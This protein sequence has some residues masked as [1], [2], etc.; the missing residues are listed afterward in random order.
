MGHESAM[1]RYLIRLLTPIGLW[2]LVSCGGSTALVGPSLTL[3][4]LPVLP[5]ATHLGANLQMIQDWSFTPVY[6]DLMHQARKFGSPQTPWDEAAKLGSDGWPSGDF[7]ALLLIGATKYAGNAGTYKLSFTGRAKVA[8]VAS[9]AKVINLSYDASANRSS[10]DVVLAALEDQLML[11]FTDTGTGIKN[12]KVIRPG[13]DALNPP[14]FTTAFLNHIARFKT[15]R[16]MDWLRTNNNPVT[17]WAT[18]AS[19]EKTHYASNAG[20]PW[21]HIIAL[22]NQT[23]QDIWINIP[24]AAD[25]DYVLQLAKLLKT[26]L[27]AESKVYIEYSNEIWNGGFGQYNTNRALAVAQ[28][29]GNP[30][31]TLAYDGQSTPAVLA[32]RHVAKRLKEFS[33]IF[34][35][36]HGDAAMMS[37]IRPVL[38]FQVVQAMTA[39][40]GLDFIAAVYG[41][42]SRYFYAIAGAPY[43]DLGDQQTVEGLTTDQVLQ[44]MRDSIQRTSIVGLLEAD[45][46]LASWYGLQF[47]AYEGGP[48][49]FGPGSLA[50]KKAANLD[51]R[52][53][54]LCVDYLS[55]WYRQGGGML[56]WFMAGA[57]NWDTQYG[58]WELTT[59]LTLTD[60]PKIKCMDTVLGA[61]PVSPNGR[62][63]VPGSFDALAFVGNQ[64][65]YSA[66]SA[67]RLRYLHPGA[68]LE[69]LVQAPASGTYSLVIRSEAAQTGN[70]IELAVNSSVVAAAFELSKTGWGTPADNSPVALKLEK[71]FNTLRLTTKTENQGFILSGFRV[72]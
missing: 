50:A 7:G 41:P 51:P 57:G 17:S 9:S 31:S 10:A 16:F 56:M 34:R 65:P 71:G 15:L 22:A 61:P 58:A 24:V 69:Y 18:R 63:Q 33:D 28:V 42:P 49:T 26:S 68:V 52:M 21:E 60:T 54:E 43:F 23:G 48:A 30:A 13:Y 44:A 1:S 36:V 20:V 37:T 72:Y 29:Q 47:V 12:V 11:A 46:A 53:H 70:S 19:P 66:D 3:P 4:V 27:N 64:P 59:D 8:G 35:G 14:L 45:L 39:K 2:L 38:G 6:V 62:N 25:D 67:L 32:F 40:L 55:R 5:V